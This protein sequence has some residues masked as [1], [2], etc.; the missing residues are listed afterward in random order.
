[1]SA[2]ANSE[3]VLKGLMQDVPLMISSLL[4]FAA[5]QHP[6]VELVTRTVEDPNVYHRTTY[7]T[8]LQRV[9]KL[10]NVLRDR[11]GV[12][13]GDRIATLAWNTVRHFELFHAVSGIGAV[14]H[15]LNPRLYVEQLVYIINHAADSIIFVDVT[16]LKLIEQLRPHINCKRFVVMTDEPHMPAS[17]KPLSLN[18]VDCAPAAPFR[19]LCYE[20]L[21]ESERGRTDWAWPTFDERTA[22]SLCYTSGTTGNPKAVLYSHRSTILHSMMVCQ[23]DGLGLSSHDSIFLIVPMFHA[24][25]WGICYAAPMCGAKLVFPGEHLAGP[26]IYH[27]LVREKITFTCGVPT[28]WLALFAHIDSLIAADKKGAMKAA[29]GRT[30]YL[31]DLQRVGIGGSACPPAMIKRFYCE[32]AQPIIILHIW[33][34]VKNAALHVSCI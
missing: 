5:K 13:P 23:R 20:Q 33:G 24:N 19:A 9:K 26:D 31:P 30:K 12:K 3:P 17:C 2:A 34:F 8:V 11:F 29:D 22:S 21:I 18:L 27:Q 1:M 16:L 14:L 32:F 15:T 25:A 28:V 4:E 10:S 6:S 7:G